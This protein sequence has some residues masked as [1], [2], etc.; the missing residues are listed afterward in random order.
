MS[1][2]LDTKLTEM[3][4]ENQNNINISLKID[5][6]S[7]TDGK[8]ESSFNAKYNK[9]EKLFNFTFFGTPSNEK[10]CNEIYDSL[11]SILPANIPKSSITANKTLNKG[12]F[13]FLGGCK[14]DLTINNLTLKNSA[15]NELS[16]PIT[17]Q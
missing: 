14:I 7:D 17:K 13:G 12:M 5:G 9:K 4:I 6:H 11:L 1:S 2:V 3:D 10:E 8:F 15:V 16:E